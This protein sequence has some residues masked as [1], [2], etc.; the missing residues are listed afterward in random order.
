MRQ[1][2]RYQSNPDPVQQMSSTGEKTAFNCDLDIGGGGRFNLSIDILL[3]SSMA[4]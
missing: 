2:I 3:L 1:T 4:K